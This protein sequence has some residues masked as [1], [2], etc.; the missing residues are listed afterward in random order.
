MSA[1]YADGIFLWISAAE[2][3]PWEPAPDPD[4]H[5][6]FSTVSSCSLTLIVVHMESF[7]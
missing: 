5:I 4:L 1:Q 2:K 3:M 7:E 6:A